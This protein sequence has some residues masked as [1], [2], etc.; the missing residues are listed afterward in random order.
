M[1][2]GEIMPQLVN[3]DFRP[4]T[5][6]PDLVSPHRRE[7]AV[8]HSDSLENHKSLAVEAGTGVG[9]SLAYLLSSVGS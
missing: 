1:A 4:V 6:Q 8:S 3:N 5:R 2:K 9:K 7:T